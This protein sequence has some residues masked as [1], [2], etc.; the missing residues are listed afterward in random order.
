MVPRHWRAEWD[1]LIQGPNDALAISLPG[2]RL[3]QDMQVLGLTW[4]PLLGQWESKTTS[5]YFEQKPW[6]LQLGDVF[7][8]KPITEVGRMECQGEL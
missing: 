2:G 6:L 7:I 1:G 5:Q 4:L 8:A 3:S